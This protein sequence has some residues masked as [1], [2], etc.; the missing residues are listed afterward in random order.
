MKQIYLHKEAGV[1]IHDD[2]TNE[3]VYLDTLEQAAQDAEVAW[4][5]PDPEIVRIF[6]LEDG[7]IAVV[8]ETT[9]GL[10]QEAASPVIQAWLEQVATQADV[11]VQKQAERQVIQASAADSEFNI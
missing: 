9:A 3:T 10:R 11:L 8:R 2:V 4:N 5:W 1:R 7:R 6:P